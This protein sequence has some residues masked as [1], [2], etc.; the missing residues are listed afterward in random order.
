[1][2]GL[3]RGVARTA[4]VGSAIAVNPVTYLLKPDPAYGV[5]CGTCGDGWT[6]SSDRVWC[7]LPSSGPRHSLRRPGWVL[8]DASSGRHLA[9]LR[10]GG[11]NARQLAMSP[12]RTRVLLLSE[13]PAGTPQ[14]FW[15]RLWVA[16]ADGSD[17]R[18]LHQTSAKVDVAGWTSDGNVIVLERD[19]EAGFVRIIRI[20]TDTGAV[21]TL[22]HR[23]Q[24]W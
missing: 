11:D 18:E 16:S 6:A 7:R 12:D 24:R 19:W 22:L 15:C 10:P 17:C 23:P 3:L 20:D 21:T 2:P 9:S 8:I 13:I 14:Q 5:V 4:V 1:M